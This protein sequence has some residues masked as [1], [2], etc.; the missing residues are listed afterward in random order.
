[1]SDILDFLTLIGGMLHH[2]ASCSFLHNIHILCI[3]LYIDPSSLV[4]SEFSIFEPHASCCF[5][6]LT[7]I[8]FYS[9]MSMLR[10]NCGGG[11]CL[12]EPLGTPENWQCFA[13]SLFRPEQDVKDKVPLKQFLVDKNGLNR[14]ATTP[15]SHPNRRVTW[16]DGQNM[17]QLRTHESERLM[18]T[19]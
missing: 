9:V 15:Q 8:Q 7:S 10:H 18:G 14:P 16:L 2:A 3:W 19:V 17:S 12:A 4:W 13:W 11:S 5:V 1:M 6:L